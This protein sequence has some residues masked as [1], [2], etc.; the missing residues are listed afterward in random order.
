MTETIR[1]LA[2]LFFIAPLLLVFITILRLVTLGHI[3]L[4]DYIGSYLLVLPNKI[5]NIEQEAR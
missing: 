1:F 4:R 2:A 5:D 3:D